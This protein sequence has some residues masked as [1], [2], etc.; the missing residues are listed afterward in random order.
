[1]PEIL[2]QYK[3]SRH[4]HSHLKTVPHIRGCLDIVSFVPFF[5]LSWRHVARDWHVI[6]LFLLKKTLKHVNDNQQ[7]NMSAATRGLLH[8]GREE[9]RGRLTVPVPSSS[10]FVFRGFSA[11]SARASVEVEERVD[12]RCLKE[13]SHSAIVLEKI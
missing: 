6:P 13:E 5:L 9:A 4:A 2:I 8:G 7:V 10:V 3:R 1:M 12:S 11:G